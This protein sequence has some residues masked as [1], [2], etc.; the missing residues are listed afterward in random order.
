M[1]KTEAGFRERLGHWV[2]SAPVQKFIV[3]VIIFNAITLGLETSPWMQ[4][5]VGG[6]LRATEIAI[7]TIFVAE[8][9]L[10]LFA[11]GPRFFLG[12]WN[13]FDFV[14]VAISLVPAAGAFSVLR[15]L[16]IVRAL[17]LL[18]AIPR[19]RL[20]VEGVLRVLPDMGWVFTLLMLVFYVFSVIGTKL[21]AA[22][23]PEYFGNIPLTMLTLFQVMTLESWA[24]GVARP[25]LAVHPAAW[26]YF[27]PFILFTSF[28]IVNMIIG[29][30]V[31][32]FQ[33][34]LQGDEAPPGVPPQPLEHHVPV[35]LLREIE[36]LHRK[37]DSLLEQRGEA[38]TDPAVAP[39]PATDS[40]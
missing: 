24:S 30:V 14:I 20:I 4:Q 22:T 7:L 35:D 5:N 39:P 19:L 6:L 36:E 27:V 11:F 23:F 12:A 9:G 21:Y 18:K 28:L 8:I 40:R 13:V 31:N 2:E 29:V 26:V 3:A 16:R 37:L 10:K 15:T 1:D 38:A 32:G 25:V 17:R 34:V 33:A